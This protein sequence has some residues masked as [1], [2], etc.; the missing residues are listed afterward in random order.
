MEETALN[1]RIEELKKQ[2]KIEEKVSEKTRAFM[3]KKQS[4][5]EGKTEDREQLMHT[6]LG[7]LGEKKQEITQKMDEANK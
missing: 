7:K 5:I 2:L 6:E 3:V 1:Q 4:L